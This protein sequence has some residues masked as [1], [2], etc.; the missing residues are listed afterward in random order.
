VQA[1][2]QHTITEAFGVGTAA[3]VAPIDLIGIADID[4]SFPVYTENNI[5]F[6]L[7]KI[8]DDIRTGKTADMYNWNFVCG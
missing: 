3:V 1:F 6:R 4:Y 2:N 5:M 8:L 7:K